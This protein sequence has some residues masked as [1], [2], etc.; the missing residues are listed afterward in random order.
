MSTLTLRTA[1]GSPL[2]NAE[3][4]ANFTNLLVALG[5]VNT[6][7][8]TVPTPTGTGSP[9]LSTAP[10]LSTAYIGTQANATRFPHALAVV[11]S[12]ASG[13]QYNESHNIGLIAEGTAHASDANVYGIGLYG[14][15]YTSA[16][17]RCGGVVGEAHVSASSDVGSAIGVRGHSNDTHAG[18]LNVGLYGDATSGSSNYALYLN[19][20]DI[21]TAGAKSWLLNGNLSF[22]GAYSVSIPTLNLTNALGA[23]NGG[24]GLTT[25]GTDG[26][27]L[28]S[29]GTT[30]S[31]ATP[32]SGL[33]TQT[34]NVGKYLKTDGSTASWDALDISTSDIS[35][36]LGTANGG[37]GLTTVGT[38]GQVLTSNGTTLSWAT[39]SGGGATLSDDTATNATYYPTFA[40]ATSGS[41]TTAKVSSTQL[42]F[43]P[44]TGMFSA[45]NFTSLSDASL[46]ENVQHINNPIDTLNQLEG[47]SYNWKSNGLLSYGFI[48]QEVEKVLPAIVATDDAGIKSIQYN[49]LIAFLTEAV[50]HQNSVIETL[51]TRLKELEK[52]RQ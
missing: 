44:S 28:T 52:P 20:G 37:T 21:Y 33:P 13:I 45:T 10:T 5:G 46:K 48:A 34:G 43:N 27:V 8:Y 25:V 35:G 24:T 31:W 3:V 14:V 32:A 41:M 1:K 30:L 7:P 22:S 17:T 4:D 12:T 2:T 40:T 29:N 49:S 6:S 51:D 42:Q 50:K 15:G 47:V 39:P 36:A 23:A 19:S 38:D 26:Q 16:T 11:A 9:V 18:G